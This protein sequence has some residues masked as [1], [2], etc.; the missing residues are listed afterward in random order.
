MIRR[1]ISSGIISNANRKILQF[2]SREMEFQTKKNKLQISLAWEE[3]DMLRPRQKMWKFYLFI[4]GSIS[5]DSDCTRNL[6][7]YYQE[8]QVYKKV[9]T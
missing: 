2:E 8:I 6:I 7:I 3:A 1:A 9:L 4:W 5:R